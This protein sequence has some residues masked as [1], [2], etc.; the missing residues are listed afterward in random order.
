[1]AL[2]ALIL[3]VTGIGAFWLSQNASSA[4]TDNSIHIELSSQPFP[5]IVGQNTL[6]VKLTRGGAPVDGARVSVEAERAMQGQMPLTAAT[7]TSADGLYRIPIIW[8]AAERWIVNVS[9][10]LGEETAADQFTVYVFSVPEENKGT[11]VIY[12]GENAIAAERERHPEQFWIVIP[13]GTAAQI[14]EGHGDDV[15]PSEINLRVDGQNTLVVQ[16]NDLADHTIGPFFVRS[17]ET[18]RQTYS[19]PQ[20][21][22]GVC[23]VRHDAVVK[24]IVE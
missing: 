7:N 19:Q 24:I 22:E 5:L 9:A 17:G 8:S 1:M 2:I 3:V 6:L 23:S 4:L 14:R 11:R 18:L 15:M 12:A 10:A 20:V 21:Y 13:Q 16:N